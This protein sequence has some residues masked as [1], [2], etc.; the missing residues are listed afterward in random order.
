MT[1]LF[2]VRHG[3]AEGNS[4]HRFIGHS[5]TRLTAVGRRQAESVAERLGRLPVARIVTSDLVRCVE[6]VEPLADALGLEIET[7][8]RLREV[9][10]GEWT[11]LLPEEIAERW[12]DL[13]EAYTTGVDVERPGGER[14]RDVAERVLT[15]IEEVLDTEEPVV[16]ATHSGPTLILAMWAA[17]LRQEGNIFSGPLSAPHNAS[18]TVIGEGPRL[19]SYNDVGHVAPVPDQRLPFSPVKNP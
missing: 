16:V 9:A 10:N 17:G 3:E 18:I 13:W 1:T 7:D 6:T 15:A 11:G 19:I 12:P 5:Q 14:W 8:P 2:V 4:D